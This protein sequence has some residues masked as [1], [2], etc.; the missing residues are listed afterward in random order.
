MANTNRDA[1]LKVFDGFRVELDEYND[2]RERLIKVSRDI[3]NASKKVIFLLHRLATAK[4]ES[5]GTDFKSIAKQGRD[6][7]IEIQALFA[8]IRGELDGERFWSFQRA[9]SPGLQE[10]IEALSFVHYLESGRLVTFREVQA[11]LTDESG[12]VYFP[13]PLDDYLLG[14]S[15]LTGELM[16]YAI[17][18]ISH[19]G[20]RNK[21]K[22]VCDFVRNCK[23]D[24]ERFTPFVKFLS[25]KQAV[26][27]Q[28]LEKI[29]AA[30]YTIAIRRSE[31]GASAEALE[32]LVSGY[33]S[34]SGME[35][36]GRGRGDVEGDDDMFP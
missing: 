26:T 17:V 13:L 21:A 1:V 16:R 2:R 22:E 19:R 12:I 30:A 15:D 23:A 25:K 8:S 20:G 35:R 29:E 18:A 34:S 32:D 5:G 36:Q 9:V 10:Y 27:S 24:F 14:V 31:Y 3:T 11:S 28:S 7:L 33:E 4:I 6:K